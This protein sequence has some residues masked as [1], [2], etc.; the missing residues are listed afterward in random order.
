MQ[1]DEHRRR[2]KLSWSLLLPELRA[3]ESAMKVC[4]KMSFQQYSFSMLSYL[5][6]Y[7]F[8]VCEKTVLN[9]FYEFREGIDLFSLIA[10][11]FTWYIYTSIFYELQE[12]TIAYLQTKKMSVGINYIC[13]M[14]ESTSSRLALSRSHG[15][16]FLWGFF[17]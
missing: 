4:F 1:V 15:F 3:D 9:A 6:I 14:H 2:E 12:L 7:M 11:K 13:L 8:A 16:W 5:K 17:W 10:L